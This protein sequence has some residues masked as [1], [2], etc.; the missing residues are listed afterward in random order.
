M[1]S[2]LPS[3]CAGSAARRNASAVCVS[4]SRRKTRERLAIAVKRRTTHRSAATT[5]AGSAWLHGETNHHQRGD[6]KERHRVERVALRSSSVT[7][8]RKTAPA[9]STQPEDLVSKVEFFTV[10]GRHHQNA[11]GTL[12]RHACARH[13]RPRSSRLAVG[14]SRRSTGDHATGHSEPQALAHP[15][16]ERLRSPRALSLQTNLGQQGIQV[17]S[18]RLSRARARRSAGSPAASA[19]VE[20]RSGLTRPTSLHVAPRHATSARYSTVPRVGRRSPQRCAGGSFAGSIPPG[21]HQ[22]LPA[23]SKLTPRKRP[24]PPNLWPDRGQPE[25]PSPEPRGH[26]PVIAS[27]YRSR[28]LLALPPPLA[29]RGHYSMNVLRASKQNAGRG[30]ALVLVVGG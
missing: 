22:R 11:S 25:R 12:P 21:D 6:G 9:S 29:S 3:T 5:L 23:S 15:G 27:L 2:S 30:T 4:S 28:V 7:S 8:F 14:S 20:H 1:K 18:V 16:R 17:A 26:H 10:V 19:L 24:C 13:R